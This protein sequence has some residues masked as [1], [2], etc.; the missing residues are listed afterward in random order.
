MI[1][2]AIAIALEPHPDDDIVQVRDK[3][4]GP[5]QYVA[6]AP[7]QRGDTSK[8][9]MADMLDS[10][11]H[12]DTASRHGKSFRPVYRIPATMFEDVYRWIDQN[13]ET[14]G[15][16][17]HDFD[18]CGKPAVR[19]KLKLLASFF[20]LSTGLLDKGMA[21]QIGCDEETMRVFFLRF[22]RTVSKEQGPKWIKLPSTAEQLAAHVAS[23]DFPG[24]LPGCM[25]SIDCTHI[26][27]CRARTSV[28]S[29]QVAR[30]FFWKFAVDSSASGTWARKAFQPWHFKF[31]ASCMICLFALHKSGH[32]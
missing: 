10:N 19:L 5:R 16:Q 20:R 4:K 32:R 12:L 25:G 28:K 7:Q 2:A 18:C 22:I 31:A 14:Y 26:G 23:Y 29:W 15:F 11:D 3:R 8:S 17:K 9:Q 30:Y 13:R 6:R 1:S 24:G 21:N 27:W